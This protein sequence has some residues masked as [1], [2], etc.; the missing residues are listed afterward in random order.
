M[1][2]SVEESK[3]SGPVYYWLGEIAAARA[4]EKEFREEG[5]R[6]LSIYNGEK[7]NSI[8]FNILYSNTETLLPALYS[9]TP[10]PVVDRRFKD[11]DP[12]GKAAS[13][14]GQRTLE[15]LVDT[16]S[17][18]Y[19][20]F[21]DVVTDAVLDA[22]LPGRAQTRV[23]YDFE[24][25]SVNGSEMVT[26]ETIC[27]ESIKWDRWTFGYSKKWKR[28]PWVGLE[29]AVTKKEATDLFGPAKANLLTYSAENNKDEDE[30][31]DDVKDETSEEQDQRTAI[32]WEIWDKAGGK[33][34]RFIAESYKADYLKVDADPL[35]LTGFYPMPEPLR[36]HKKSNDQM[37]VAIYKLYENQAKELNRITVRINK[38]VEACKVRGVYD[39]TLKEDLENLLKKDD[40][41]MVGAENVAALQNGGLDKAIWLMP[42][43]KLVAVLQQ[44]YVAREAC[45]RTIYEI[46]GISDILRGASAASE[47]LGAQ[48]IKQNWAT[49]R[50][51]RMQKEVARYARDLL[52]ITL[53]IAGSK[54]KQETFQKVTGLPFPTNQDKQAIG[55]QLAALKAQ[56]AMAQQQG[57]PPQP[58][59]PQV[60]QMMQVLQMPSWE[61]AV[62]VL[63]NDVERQYKTDIET[64]STV[65]LD[66]T[67]DKKNLAEVMNAISQFLNGVG[68]LVQSGSLSIEAAKGFLLF[69]VRKYRMGVDVEEYIKQMQA[70]KPQ[71]DG[72]AQQAAHDAQLEQAKLQQK[73]AV[74]KGQAQMQQQKDLHAVQMEQV[75]FQADMAMRNAEARQSQAIE[76]AKIEAQKSSEL[77]K[78]QAQRA[79]EE[80]KA[81]LQ[82]ETELKKAALV[83]ATQIE[84]AQINAK[85]DAEASAGETAVAGAQVA[86]T[87]T[88][89]TK[90][91]ET[92]EKLMEL[93]SKPQP[94]IDIKR[95]GAGKMMSLVPKSA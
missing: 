93:I 78:L 73:D 41:Q 38:V 60:Q 12:V 26:Y 46:T 29:H 83:A 27:Y 42:I 77:A 7:P 49:L 70:P 20:G 35:G 62:K 59:P 71:D 48:E 90:I 88:M 11:D 75:K 74:D 4:R 94:G 68:P 85:K 63:R 36:L 58:P 32:V 50:L 33:K 55:G 67:E 95:D 3:K 82:Q 56:M 52:R 17:E 13:Q 31:A 1:S 23:K 80:M 2:D 61:D 45:K 92:Q 30:K 86:E 53:E 81:R 5:R 22:L 21:D 47:T 37:P 79:T 89:M 51:K 19:A 69:A 15:Y 87:S 91:L 9:N 65:D 39:S 76:M 84:I 34:V 18:E 44:L 25:G 14:I 57:Q 8:P 40:N 16:N 24:S 72:K 6:V 28:V 54:F 64:N 10:R 66:A 43:E